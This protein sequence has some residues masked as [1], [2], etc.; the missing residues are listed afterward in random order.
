MSPDNGS[1]VD[2]DRI[3]VVVNGRYRGND[4]GILSYNHEWEYA[5]FGEDGTPEILR[6]AFEF[7]SHTTYAY[8]STSVYH[9]DIIS[10]VIRQKEA[11]AV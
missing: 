10:F 1:K 5:V 2:K 4:L 7:F 9:H 6:Y 8:G 11:L 3:E